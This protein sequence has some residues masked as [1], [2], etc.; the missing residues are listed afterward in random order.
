MKDWLEKIGWKRLVEDWLEKI[1]FPKLMAKS[2]ATLEMFILF[3]KI[4]L[5]MSERLLLGFVDSIIKK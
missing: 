5:W 3:K 4:G 1:T 2:N